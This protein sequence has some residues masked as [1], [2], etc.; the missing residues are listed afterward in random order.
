MHWTNQYSLIP[1]RNRGI[2]NRIKALRGGMLA[3]FHPLQITWSNQDMHLPRGGSGV[4]L[5]E[6]AKCPSVRNNLGVLR[7][8][9][10][11][12]NRPFL[13]VPTCIE[14][15]LPLEMTYSL[16]LINCPCIT[17]TVPS[18]L[19][20]QPSRSMRSFSSPGRADAQ[21]DYCKITAYYK[22]QRLMGTHPKHHY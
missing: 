15:F 7:Y 14:Q 2:K 11:E 12:E 20:T 10:G 18:M 22:N 5:Q 9:D 6:H 3:S 21:T 8:R 16:S 17:D 4:F 1:S 19:G 13:E